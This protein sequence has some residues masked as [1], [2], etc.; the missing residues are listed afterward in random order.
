MKNQKKKKI[1][2]KNFLQI[3][4]KILKFFRN[5]FFSPNPRAIEFFK[6]V[7]TPLPLILTNRQWYT[8]S[9]DPHAR[10]EWLINKYG[11]AHALLTNYF[12]KSTMVYYIKGPSCTF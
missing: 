9:K 4:H 1:S 5:I 2:Q 3:L 11:R 12:N 7:H 10:F 6:F 8:I